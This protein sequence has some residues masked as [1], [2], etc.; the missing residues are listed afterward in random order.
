MIVTAKGVVAC[1]RSQ[2][3]STHQTGRGE[4]RSAAAIRIRVSNGRSQ[5][6]QSTHREDGSDGRR[7]IVHTKCDGLRVASDEVQYAAGIMTCS[8]RGS[9]TG[10]V[11]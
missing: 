11:C 2:R 7:S 1:C 9:K 8:G 3:A 4:M 5:P 10:S 6:L